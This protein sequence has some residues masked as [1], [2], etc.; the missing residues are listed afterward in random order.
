MAHCRVHTVLMRN[1]HDDTP[2]L[3]LWNTYH[4]LEDLVGVFNGI[5]SVD[6]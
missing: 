3:L 1:I 5:G 2:L 4:N 6:G